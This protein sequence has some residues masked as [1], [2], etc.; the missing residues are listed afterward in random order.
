M[1]LVPFVTQKSRD[2]F[3]FPGAVQGLRLCRVDSGDHG[4]LGVHGV[5]SLN[6]FI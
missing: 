6:D 1:G 4:D 3:G 2:G 5:H